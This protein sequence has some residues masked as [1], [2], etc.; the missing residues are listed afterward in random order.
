MNMKS[1]YV[2]IF[3]KEVL[4]LLPCGKHQEKYIY[5]IKVQFHLNRMVPGM[6]FFYFTDQNLN[7]RREYLRTVRL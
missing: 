7:S 4:K 6:V 3:F 5:K 2:I 1:S